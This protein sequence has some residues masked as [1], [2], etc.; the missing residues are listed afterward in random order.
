MPFAGTPVVLN[1]LGGILGTVQ[2]DALVSCVSAAGSPS[3]LSGGFD[4]PWSW[5][6]SS[7]HDFGC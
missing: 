7:Y 6:H 4:G 2:D 3:D 5:S 1:L